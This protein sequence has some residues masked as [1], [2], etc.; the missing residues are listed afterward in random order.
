MCWLQPHL[1]VFQ[2]ATECS[3]IFHLLQWL[4]SA[5]A[6]CSMKW[7]VVPLHLRA[8]CLVLHVGNVPAVSNIPLLAGASSLPAQLRMGGF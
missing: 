5:A 4:Y 8:S 7:C 1:C 3:G 6:H 2:H